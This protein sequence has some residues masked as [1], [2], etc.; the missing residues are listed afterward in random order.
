MKWVREWMSG[1]KDKETEECQETKFLQESRLKKFVQDFR[2][3]KTLQY[4]SFALTNFIT[5]S[6]A[7]TRTR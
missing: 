6:V 3:F 2:N 5:L 4:L 7:N 1:L